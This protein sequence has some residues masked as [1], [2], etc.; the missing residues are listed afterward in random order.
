M[1][2]VIYNYDGT[3]K[4]KNLNEVINQGNHNVNSFF[5]AIDGRDIDYFTVTALFRLPNES[6]VVLGGEVKTETIGEAQYQ[7]YEIKLTRDVTNFPGY[8]KMSVQLYHDNAVL[9]TIEIPLFV[10]ETPYD[11]TET[12]ISVE[13]YE[14][15]LQYLNN[16]QIKYS[17]NNVRG[18]RSTTAI[19]AEEIQNL[20]SGQLVLRSNPDIPN[21]FYL[22]VKLANGTLQSLG[23]FTNEV[24]LDQRYVLQDNATEIIYGTD[25]EGN[26]DKLSY[27][28]TANAYSIVQRDGSGQITVPVLPAEN[29]HA[30]SKYYVDSTIS[31]RITGVYKIAGSGSITYLNSGTNKT[32]S[33]NGSVFNLSDSGNLTNYDSSTVSVVAGDNVVFVWNEGNW[34]WDKMSGLIDLSGYYAKNANLVPSV[35]DTYDLGASATK[36]HDIWLSNAINLG[37]SGIIKYENGVFT[38]NDDI[39]PAVTNNYD[40]GS[41]TNKW[42]DLYING[43]LYGAVSGWD[44]RIHEVYMA[45]NGMEVAV[46]TQVDTYQLQVYGCNY[47][48][49]DSSESWKLETPNLQQG[50]HPVINGI[51]VGLSASVS[52][53]FNAD[54][55]ICNDDSIAYTSGTHTITVT[56]TYGTYEFSLQDDRLVLVNFNI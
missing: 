42:K 44:I 9:R 54:Y 11:P 36:F 16:F 23:T 15:L 4:L 41:S 31:M 39:T 20:A 29:Y 5:V 52:V 21:N 19:S 53:T 28:I 34:Y 30:A 49:L 56:L 37:T 12:P 2:Y 1:M 14:A 50:L 18:Y 40:L 22:Y 45:L 27:A 46:D 13:Q 25:D 55:F 26:Q 7:G 6:V 32:S 33:L 10:N 47:F 24:G 8:V 17:P 35:A 38:Y 3:I 51:I 48:E 43:T